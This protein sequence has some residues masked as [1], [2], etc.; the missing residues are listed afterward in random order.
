MFLLGWQKLTDTGYQSKD[1]FSPLL[2][3]LLQFHFCIFITEHFFFKSVC[4]SLQLFLI[5]HSPQWVWREYGCCLDRC[6]LSYLLT[7]VALESNA[8]TFSIKNAWLCKHWFQA[9]ENVRRSFTVVEYQLDRRWTEQQGNCAGETLQT[10]AATRGALCQEVIG[11]K[12][13]IF[14]RLCA[15][16]HQRSRCAS[17]VSLGDIWIICWPLLPS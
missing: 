11:C 6:R 15:L 7:W 17:K 2:P 5:K 1:I 4:A 9:V 12:L 3:S 8:S 13:H 16:T 10:L 14:T